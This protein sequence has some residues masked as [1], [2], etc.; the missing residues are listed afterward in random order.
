MPDK[1]VA[2]IVHQTASSQENSRAVELE[3]LNEKVQDA[4]QLV[5]E[6]A[7]VHFEIATRL[8]PDEDHSF[9]N[10]PFEPDR[11]LS[12]RPEDFSDIADGIDG[13]YVLLHLAP[14][15]SP[16][17]EF[18]LGFRVGTDGNPDLVIAQYRGDVGRSGSYVQTAIFNS[19]E[20]YTEPTVVASG[21]KFDEFEETLSA[22]QILAK[23]YAAFNRD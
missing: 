7:T 12:F 2:S 10:D 21:R 18:V 19:S 3:A 8:P 5:A 23:A 16:R 14:D 22:D 6:V 15:S 4:V 20:L 17:D 9:F 1:T 11:Y 13:N